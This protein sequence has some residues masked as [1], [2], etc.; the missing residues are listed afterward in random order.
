L[1]RFNFGRS[2]L[3]PIPFLFNTSQKKLNGNTSLA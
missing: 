3:I 1:K 2:G